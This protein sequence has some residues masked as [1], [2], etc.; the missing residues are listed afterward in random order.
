MLQDSKIHPRSRGNIVWNLGG[1]IWKVSKK[2]YEIISAFNEQRPVS[3]SRHSWRDGLLNIGIDG[4][5]KRMW[6]RACVPTTSIV[7]LMPLLLLRR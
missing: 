7:W 2:K 4:S 6:S 5:R 1:N 3:Y